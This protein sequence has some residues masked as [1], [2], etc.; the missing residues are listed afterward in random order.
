M[1]SPWPELFPIIRSL[2]TE[3]SLLAEYHVDGLYTRFP[4]LTEE[5][6]FVYGGFLLFH[7]LCSIL[8]PGKYYD[9]QP[10][11]DGKKISYKIN[12]F[13][14]FI[15]LLTL[16][17]GG[18]Y[19]GFFDPAYAANNFGSLSLVVFLWSFVLSVLL[20]FKGILSKD[21][22]ATG[23]P[24]YDFIIGTQLNPSFLGVD[25]KMYSLKPGMMGWT[26]LNLSFAAKQLQLYGSLSSPMTF[27]QLLSFIYVFDY[28][29]HEPRMLST[30]DIV[31]EHF[32]FMLVFGDYWFIP[33]TFCIQS[34]YLVTPTWIPEWRYVLNVVV[35]LVGSYI[36]RTANSQ[37]DEY[38]TKGK[39]AIIW[40]EPP[41]LIA[42]K[43]LYSGFWG[44][45]RKPN[46]TGDIL[47]AIA[48]S[49]M[50]DPIATPG[51][52]FYPFYLTVLLIHRAMRDDKKCREKYKKD[53]VE[54]CKKV[55]KQMIPYIY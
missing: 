5:A 54:Y 3:Y 43:L 55:P 28:F 27:Y 51:A 36:F 2:P 48:F 33:F 38:K 39:N 11:A 4:L 14:I 19:K 8:I 35:F 17:I 31:S 46:Y 22:G 21:N 6:V 42:G 24:I 16:F 44:I 49:L 45:V 9:G 29:Y 20:Y 10:L 25:I 34:I 50:C 1:T 41:K 30:W 52:Y 18:G 32:G 53:W 37:K 23:S 12:G 47:V 26:I 40:G 13:R 7:F 15:I